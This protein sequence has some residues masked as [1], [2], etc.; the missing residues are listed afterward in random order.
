VEPAAKTRLTTALILAVVF[1]SG[2][3]LGLAADSSLQAESPTAEAETQQASADGEASSEQP[4]AQRER[5]YIYQQ[6]DPNEEQLARIEV[7]VA[8]MRERLDAFDE[9]SRARWDE[10]RQE[11]YLEARSAIKA[12]LSP[13][14]AAEYTRLYDEWE[15]ERA[16]ERENEDDRN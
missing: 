5:R 10:G 1:G 7:I 6:V 4:E 8:E 2:V 16:A 12:V 15:A 9:E 11:F 14:Q 3:L 13:E